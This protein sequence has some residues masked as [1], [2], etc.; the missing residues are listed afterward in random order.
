MREHCRQWQLKRG[1]SLNAS[2]HSSF[3]CAVGSADARDRCQSCSLPAGL[4]RQSQRF[5]QSQAG[6]GDL[7]P[8]SR[9]GCRDTNGTKKGRSMRLSVFARCSGEVGCF[10]RPGIGKV[11]IAISRAANSPVCGTVLSS[12]QSNQEC[13]RS[14]VGEL[15]RM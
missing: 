9:R 2:E 7:S 3:L 1:R 12:P 15:Q 14:K 8:R 13:C 10:G 6:L 11:R 4:V 5:Q